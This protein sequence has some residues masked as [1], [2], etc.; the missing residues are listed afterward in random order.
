MERDI[1][2]LRVQK[3]ETVTSL[4][5]T[6]YGG[7]TSS[8]S[9]TLRELKLNQVALHRADGELEDRKMAL[10]LKRESME[11]EC[12]ELQNELF[13]LEKRRELSAAKR[14]Q[15]ESA[16]KTPMGLHV[17]DDIDLMAMATSKQIAGE[18][19]SELKRLQKVERAQRHC[20]KATETEMARMDSV[21]ASTLNQSERQKKRKRMRTRSEPTPSESPT[22]ESPPPISKGTSKTTSRATSRRRES[23]R[24]RLEAVRSE[25]E[26]AERERDAVQET[27]SERESLAERLHQE[28]N[29]CIVSKSEILKMAHQFENQI[30]SKR[31][32]SESASRRN[33]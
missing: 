5:H 8:E 28:A 31:Y 32:R 17:D 3:A 7:T 29:D 11:I 30:R 33:R 26:E 10:K 23:V 20:L 9:R 15:I 27:V 13:C 1:E 25:R 16:F 21:I 18:A 14:S 19:L 12:E 6:V 4:I 24:E 22:T 2:R